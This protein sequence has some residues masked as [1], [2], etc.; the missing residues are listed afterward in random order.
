MTWILTSTGKHFDL[1][2]PQPDMIDVIDIASAL[3]NLCR[4]SGH[5]RFYYSVA[6]HS[7]MASQIVP[8]E[9][10]MEAL[11]HDASE[12]YLGDITRPLKQLLP[13]YRQIEHKVEGA[14]RHRFGLP[15]AQSYPVTMADRVMLATER[16]DLMVSDETDWPILAGITPL[17]NRL[18]A[19][20]SH[21]AKTL[22]MTRLI[23]VIQQ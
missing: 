12:A 1:I 10:A 9:F 8:P 16:R 23:E 15:D 3:A 20:N 21:R 2:D 18:I 14:I 11:L 6:Q 4:F 13:D 17:A 7:A 5:C 22:F 19:V